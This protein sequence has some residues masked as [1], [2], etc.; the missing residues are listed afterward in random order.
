MAIK[1]RFYLNAVWP[2]IALPKVDSKLSLLFLLIWMCILKS[3]IDFAKMNKQNVKNE[4]LSNN[5]FLWHTS[6][7]TTN[8]QSSF[9]DL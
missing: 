4:N 7:L 8:A 6:L 3:A 2:D 5:T 9:D 1:Q